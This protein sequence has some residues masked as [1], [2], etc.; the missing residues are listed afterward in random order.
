MILFIENPKKYKLMYGDRK[1]INSCLRMGARNAVQGQQ[2][3][4]TKRSE[5]I[6]GEDRYAHYPDYGDG[7]MNVDICQNLSA[8]KL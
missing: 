5:E 3:K 8:Y 6:L 4:K 7:F 1:K 2:E